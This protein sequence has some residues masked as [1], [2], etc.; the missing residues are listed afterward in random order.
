MRSYSQWCSWLKIIKSKAIILTCND[1]ELENTEGNWLINGLQLYVSYP[2]VIYKILA[3]RWTYELFY[4]N[5][6][7]ITLDLLAMPV[8][9]IIVPLL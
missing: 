7:I 2:R 9:T 1:I 3:S 8:T 4:E 5:L 6:A